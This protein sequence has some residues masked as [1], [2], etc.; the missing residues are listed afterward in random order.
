MV[1]ATKHTVGRPPTPEARTVYERWVTNLQPSVGTPE[2]QA[3]VHEHFTAPQGN[4]RAARS[5]TADAGE[6]AI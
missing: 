3:R 4:Q 2:W 6:L 1:V 5:L